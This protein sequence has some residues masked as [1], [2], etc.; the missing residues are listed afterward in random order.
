MTK[1]SLAYK[2]RVVREYQKGVRGRGLAAL[3][4]RFKIPKSVIE[5]WRKKWIQVGQTIEAFAEEVG[6]DRKSVLTEKK[7]RDTSWILSLT[8]MPK[9]KQ[10]IILIARICGQLFAE[11]Y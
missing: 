6:G 9:A 2:E 1:H 11:G 5:D 3:S 4:K 7:K 8:K 10:L